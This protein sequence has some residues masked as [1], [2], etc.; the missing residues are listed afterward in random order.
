MMLEKGRPQGTKS[1]LF[2]LGKG[3]LRLADLMQIRHSKPSDLVDPKPE[4]LELSPIKT[5]KLLQILNDSPPNFGYVIFP[6]HWS[7]V[8]RPGTGLKTGAGRETKRL[9]DSSSEI[10]EGV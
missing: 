8:C 9:C 5:L 10:M 1:N 2:K 3:K 6:Q 7:R 4:S